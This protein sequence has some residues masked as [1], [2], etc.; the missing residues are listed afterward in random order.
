VLP[1]VSVLLPTKNRRHFIPQFLR[2]FYAQNYPPGRIELVVSDDGEDCVE[3]LFEGIP[4]LTYLRQPHALTIGHKRNV[5][6]QA[7]RGDVLVHMDDDDYYPPSRIRHAVERLQAS[8]LD[9][10]G[11]S[12]MAL[13]YPLTRE[14]AVV[15]P[16]GRYHGLANTLAYTRHYLETHRFD[17]QCACGE[18]PAFTERFTA[19]MIQ[20]QP[21]KTVLVIAHN[22]NTFDKTWLQRRPLKL[23][24][25]AV[26]EDKESLRFYR[27]QLPPLLAQLRT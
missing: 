7:A 22:R 26:I 24:L 2:C 10:A 3:D 16:Y 12:E 6:A 21:Q 25:K 23:K 15:G 4:T 17:D 9:L 20:L 19:P 27:Y 8:G 18:E 13:Y 11:T 14:L 1:L 5:L